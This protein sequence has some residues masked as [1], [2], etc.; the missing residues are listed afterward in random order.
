M[1]LSEYFE[2]SKSV[3]ILSTATKEGKVN[4][5]NLAV[6]ILWGKIRLPLLRQ[7]D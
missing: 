7:I 4:A 3:G 5:A 1:K 2:Y 6:R